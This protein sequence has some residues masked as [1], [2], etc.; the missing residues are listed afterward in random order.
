LKPST[1]S[2]AE[3]RNGQVV[4]GIAGASRN[5]AAA[6]AINGQLVAFCEEERLTRIRGVGLA[7]GT[8]PQ[9]AVQTVLALAGSPSER[10]SAY[11]AAEES[12][13]LPDTLPRLRLDHH[14]GHAAAAFMTSPFESAAVLVCDR[15]SSPEMSVW[16]ARDGEVVNQQWPWSG[17]GIA[18]LY[19]ECT[20]LFG[21]SA[22]QEHRLEA[23]AR[24]GSST[25][26][27][28]VARLFRYEG[29]AIRT[30]PRWKRIVGDWL[31]QH[32]ENWSFEH[33]AEVASALQKAIGAVL[34]EILADLRNRLPAS[35]LCVGGGLFF[36]T[37]FN[38]MVARSGFFENVFVPPNP[39]NVGVAAGAALAVGQKQRPRGPED[40]AATAFLGP[41]Y[42]LE[43]IK[44]TLDNCKLSVELLQYNDVIESCVKDLAAG[45]LIGWFQGRMEWGH[46]ALGHRSIL[47]SPF[48][49]YALDNLNVFLKQREWHRAYGLSVREEETQRYFIGPSRSRW[50]EYEYQLVDTEKFRHVL[51]HGTSTLR[52]Q[53]IDPSAELFRDLHSSFAAATGAGVLI[54]TSFNG[55]SEPIVCSPRDAIRVFFG[56][57]LDVLV[58][59]R[60]VIRK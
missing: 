45:R 60:F 9:A 20:E 3:W 14:H 56:T 36:N 2:S 19:T 39:G 26:V 21:F 18:A 8:L 40:R 46:R 13:T 38:T 1:L 23:L 24:C 27:E 34:V 25:N 6:V 37:F 33:A 15:N 29:G 5:P 53:T 31:H 47:A 52:V 58:L 30:D 11:V 57:G 51:P 44:Q 54:N 59:D 48:S 16:M 41:S 32:G 49:P 12:V 7:P 28:R 42:D 55:F 17:H 10:V 4:V 22:G 50:M 35:N 43:A